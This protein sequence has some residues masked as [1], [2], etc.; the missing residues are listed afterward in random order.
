MRVSEGAAVPSQRGAPPAGGEGTAHE[1]QLDQLV[2]AI[3][4]GEV[5]GDGYLFSPAPSERPKPMEASPEQVRARLLNGIDALAFAIQLPYGQVS[6]SDLGKAI[7]ELSQSYLL[8]DPSV[9]KEGV[10]IGDRAEAEA[11]AA[12]KFPP[13]VPPNAAEAR[14]AKEHEGQSKALEHTRGQTPRPSPRVG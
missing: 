14:I 10:P 11:Q 3:I 1:Q 2:Q 13:R 5:P 7:L 4:G 8:L 6:V 9:D 12:A